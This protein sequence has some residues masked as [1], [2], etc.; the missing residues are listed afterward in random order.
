MAFARLIDKIFEE[1]LADAEV[2]WKLHLQMRICPT[3]ELCK[4]KRCPMEIF[5]I[6]SNLLQ[7]AHRVQVPVV[8]SALAFA[9]SFSRHFSSRNVYGSLCRM[10]EVESA[11]A[12][13]IV[14]PWILAAQNRVPGA[15]ESLV[16]YLR[17]DHAFAVALASYA[18]Y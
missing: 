12:M 1:E 6:L 4:E 5:R 8:L 9:H 16:R 13:N 3:V 11:I 2:A 14:R 10:T 7:Q 18:Q 15:L 17:V